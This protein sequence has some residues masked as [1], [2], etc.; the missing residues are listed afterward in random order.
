MKLS[1]VRAKEFLAKKRRQI[2]K[3][4]QR[5]GGAKAVFSKF[6]TTPSDEQLETFLV[7][8]NYGSCE[9]APFALL[10]DETGIEILVDSLSYAAESFS[11]E[12]A[13]GSLLEIDPDGDESERARFLSENFIGIS[14]KYL[15]M[16]RIK[17]SVVVERKIAKIFD[18]DFFKRNW[19][20]PGHNSDELT[21]LDFELRY[22][23]KEP[24]NPEDQW[25]STPLTHRKDVIHSIEATIGLK[26][27]LAALNLIPDDRADHSVVGHD[28]RLKTGKIVWVTPHQRK[29]PHGRK[30][31]ADPFAE[32]SYIVYFAYDHTGQLRY[33]GEGRPDRPCHVNS[34]CSHNPKLNEHF[35]RQGPM[36]IRL[37][38][39]DLSKDYAKAI[40]SYYIRKFSSSLWNVAENEYAEMTARSWEE[41][42]LDLPTLPVL[43]AEAE[44]ISLRS[45]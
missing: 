18:A 14:C 44:L 42:R 12:Y 21:G 15:E 37:V 6:E 39:S 4:I 11:E 40:E 10:G 17:A 3:D 26:S 33:V 34:G 19:K 8:A 41:H 1:E 30:H 7:E 32:D 36:K 45:G 35:Y 23:G 2:A 28:R 24:A 16:V 22:F 20:L 5:Q 43:E 27:T 13:K 25:D 38:H 9:Q 29:N 31:D